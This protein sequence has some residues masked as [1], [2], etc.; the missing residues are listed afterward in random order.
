MIFD[1]LSYTNLP[2]F[3][4]I[5]DTNL[6]EE[7]TPFVDPLMFKEFYPKNLSFSDF[8]EADENL[9]TVADSDVGE[10]SDND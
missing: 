3:S 4:K 10:S 1:V 2:S 7:E 5:R 8:I 6:D 9:V